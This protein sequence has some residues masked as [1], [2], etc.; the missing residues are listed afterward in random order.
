MLKST[1]WTLDCDQ[2]GKE[3]GF[4]LTP[5]EVEK[6][7]GVRDWCKDGWTVTIGCGYWVRC[8]ECKQ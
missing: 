5:E 4:A 6:A 7:T 2:C 8:P 1:G 3:S